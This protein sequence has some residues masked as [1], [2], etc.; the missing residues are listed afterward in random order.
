VTG[1]NMWERRL[2]EQAGEPLAFALPNLYAALGRVIP[3]LD[4]VRG[5]V[6]LA[7]G[8]HLVFSVLA[9][10]GAAGLIRTVGARIPTRF[11]QA[12]AVAAVIIVAV[13]VLL[14]D[15]IGLGTRMRLDSL[16][17]RPS[18]QTL[19]FFEELERRGD[20]GPLL[21]LPIDLDSTAY[22]MNGAGLQS[23]R[24]AYHHRRTSGCYNA[25]HPPEMAR[26]EAL[27]ARLPDAEALAEIR[28]MGFRTIVVHQPPGGPL[29]ARL[30]AASDGRT[31]RR[32]LTSPSMTAFAVLP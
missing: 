10:L 23:F 26:I 30:K 5:P 3:G 24:T 15:W 20:S 17:V 7:S 29:V 9:G 16:P 27:G 31:L 32:I 22:L 4:I 12:P 18:E 14:P 25:K 1:G 28:A 21:E 2:A 6:M 19:R 11:G 13:V 8:V